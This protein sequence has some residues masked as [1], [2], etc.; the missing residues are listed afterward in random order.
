MM[1]LVVGVLG[2]FQGQSLIDTK[3]KDVLNI[4]N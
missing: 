3:L 2:K 1:M 4:D